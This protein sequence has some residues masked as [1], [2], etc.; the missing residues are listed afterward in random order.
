MSLKYRKNQTEAPKEQL[1]VFCRK[2][3]LCIEKTTKII[4]N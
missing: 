3:Y 4:S 2:N 1:Y